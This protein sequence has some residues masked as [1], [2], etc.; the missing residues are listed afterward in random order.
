MSFF[1]FDYNPSNPQVGDRVIVVGDEML[2][3]STSIFL[4]WFTKHKGGEFYIIE[5]LG[6]N[7]V[8]LASPLTNSIDAYTWRTDWLQ[9]APSH[10][11]ADT[12]VMV[13][14]AHDDIRYRSNRNWCDDMNQYTYTARQIKSRCGDNG[15]YF[16]LDS[17][18][19]SWHRDWMFVMPEVQVQG[20]PIQ[21]E[22]YELRTV[23]EQTIVVGDEVVYPRLKRNGRVV[24]ERGIVRARTSDYVYIQGRLVSTPINKVALVSRDG[25]DMFIPNSARVA[26]LEEAIGYQIS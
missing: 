1:S 2:N 19:Y 7:Q 23:G 4:D 15:S 22:S 9:P 3:N 6:D 17:N 16:I 26:K 14:M 13:A 5:V 20:R 24:K 18:N 8:R 10:L 21:E 25:K 11:D 12:Y